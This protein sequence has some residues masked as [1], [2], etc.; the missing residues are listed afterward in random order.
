MGATGSLSARPV[1]SKRLDLGFPGGA[2][3]V[4]LVLGK[5]G[6][7]KVVGYY[8]DLGQ[9]KNYIIMALTFAQT[10]I[11]ASVRPSTKENGK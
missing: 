3:G 8:W 2:G 5:L 9:G 1:R 4:T 6:G 7:G 10:T 11:G